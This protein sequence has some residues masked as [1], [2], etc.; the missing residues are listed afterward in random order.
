[1]KKFTL[2]VALCGI[3]GLASGFFVGKRLYY[4][5]AG[6]GGSPATWA[7]IWD[8]TK[9]EQF[10]S[11]PIRPDD[12]VFV[13]TS[14]TEAFQLQEYF[15]GLPVVNRGIG[16]NETRHIVARISAIAG[17][18]PMK[19]FMEGG[20]NDLR[21]RVPAD[22][23][24]VHIRSI[25]EMAKFQSPGSKLYYCS[26]FPTTMSESGLNSSINAL[27]GQ[28]KTFCE[29]NGITYINVHDALLKGGEL[30]E[31]FTCDGMHLNGKGYEV[32]KEK[33]LPYLAV[34]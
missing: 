21:E 26:I 31:S 12:I 30:D 23:I 18:H 14:L 15:P 4:S 16:A 28:I 20:L 10:D 8:E 3:L 1:M 33:L 6:R 27:N 17:K 29:S 13:G 34:R 24:M 22:T 7:D 19:I 2:I 5:H 32:W 25:L 9:N 11:L